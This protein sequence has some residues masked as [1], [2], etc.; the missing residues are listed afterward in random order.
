MKGKIEVDFSVEYT[1]EPGVWMPLVL[2]PKYVNNN[3]LAIIGFYKEGR[4]DRVSLWEPGWS[5]GEVM[6]RGATHWMRVPKWDLE[7]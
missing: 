2:A 1:I 6:R 5:R 4:W 7:K 3:Q